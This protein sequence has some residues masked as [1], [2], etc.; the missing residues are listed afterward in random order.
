MALKLRHELVAQAV[1][2]HQMSGISRIV[3]LRHAERELILRTLEAVGWAI[4]CAASAAAKLGL[5][6]TTL[7]N[8][9]QKLGIFR[10]H[11]QSR[12]DVMLPTVQ[13]LSS[14]PKHLIGTDRADSRTR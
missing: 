9:M 6:R 8:K 2:G 4:G 3:R 13:K 1:Y 10:P 12:Q 7:I 14:V 11:L 5:K